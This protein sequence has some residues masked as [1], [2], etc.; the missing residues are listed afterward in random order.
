MKFTPESSDH[1]IRPAC[2]LADAIA[3]V[4]VILAVLAYA[5]M[6]WLTR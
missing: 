6:V 5:S 2:R 3:G 1:Q 4:V